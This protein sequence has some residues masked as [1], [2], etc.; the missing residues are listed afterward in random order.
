MIAEKK[1]KIVIHDQ[2]YTYSDLEKARNKVK[3]L[4]DAGLWYL[5][6]KEIKT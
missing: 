6:L 3:V 4:M 5:E 2:Y 1:Y